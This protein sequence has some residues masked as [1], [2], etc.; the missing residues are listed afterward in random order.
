MRK[1]K[2]VFALIL[3]VVLAIGMFA[4]CSDANNDAEETTNTVGTAADTT[5]SAS[6]PENAFADPVEISMAYWN[7][8]DNFNNPVAKDDK[9]WSEVKQ[10]FN[11]DIK[12]V[13]VTWEDYQSKFNIWAS[14]GQLPDVFISDVAGTATLANWAKNGVLKAL[15][16]DLSK[17]PEIRKLFEM[18]EYE[19]TAIDGKKYCVPRTQ[20]AKGQV[21]TSTRC[22]MVRKDWQ[23]NLGLPDPQNADE[24]L[25]LFKTMATQDADNNGIAG[26]T[27]GVTGGD[28]GA[29]LW[30]YIA[31]MFNP[32]I[33]G[34]YWIKEDGKYIP[35]HRSK[36]MYDLLA[37]LRKMVQEGAVDKD[38]ALI[39]STEG[40]ERFNTGKMAGVVWYGADPGALADAK[41]TWDK[42]LPDKR[43]ADNVKILEIPAAADG[44]RYRY[45]FMNFWS[46]YCFNAKIDDKKLD[47]VLTILDTL[48]TDEWQIKMNFGYEGTDYIKRGDSI[49][50]TT[51]KDELGKPKG[52]AQVYPIGTGFI[53][54][55]GLGPL[56]YSSDV[57]DANGLNQMAKNY[58]DFLNTK[59]TTWPSVNFQV[60]MLRTPLRDKYAFTYNDKVTE[61]MLGKEDPAKM[62]DA[63][64]AQ[65]DAAGCLQMI[66]EVNK[67]IADNNIKVD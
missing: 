32:S 31:M 37:Y 22:L 64:L 30:K 18:P 28:T 35:P 44:N 53:S 24:L 16:D 4:G 20:S 23:E 55:Y 27:Q 40:M 36:T 7:I 57:N 3:A 1:V 5:Q 42:G 14:S 63:Y 47:R 46:E 10:K 25:N 11:I 52:V 2:K 17:Y 33:V 50:I 67:A 66:D 6:E 13:N 62:W 26:D 61:I 15:P 56:S 9:L 12:P 51:P 48:C 43:F 60:Q 21:N 34:N 49:V 8:E 58:M 29:I 19:A 38:F 65:D 59:T 39:K 45:N 41:D 54:L